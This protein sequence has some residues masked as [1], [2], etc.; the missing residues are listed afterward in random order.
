[1]RIAGEQVHG[2][3]VEQDLQGMR[4]EGG[5]DDEQELAALARLEPRQRAAQRPEH[6]VMD[7]RGQHDEQRAAGRGDRHLS[8][9]A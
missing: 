8:R 1:V 4:G 3:R 9:A 5:E 7:D 6:L 2:E